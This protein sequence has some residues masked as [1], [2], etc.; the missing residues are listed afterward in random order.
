[1]S[2]SE[3]YLGTVKKLTEYGAFVS[4]P[5]GADGL[6]RRSDAN[7]TLSAGQLV[8]VEIAE[9][10]YGKPI[11]LTRVTDASSDDG[12]SG[13]T[14][15]RGSIDW[16]KGSRDWRAYALIAGVFLAI[17]GIVA[18]IM[19]QPWKSGPYADAKELFA[20]GD[21]DA[22]AVAFDELGSYGGWSGPQADTLAAVSEVA[23]TLDGSAWCAR[24]KDVARARSCLTMT[25]GPHS[26]EALAITLTFTDRNGSPTGSREYITHSFSRDMYVLGDVTAGFNDEDDGV[27][28]SM[29]SMIG[30]MFPNGTKESRLDCND[31]ESV[32]GAD[33]VLTVDERPLD[34]YGDYYDPFGTH[35]TTAYVMK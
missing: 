13:A 2:T 22:A 20:A 29:A 33:F 19:M 12:A 3:R 24:S 10:P 18:L 7:A 1:M 23:S 11:V 15:R 9:M 21:Y 6:L 25:F 28:G 34:E 5:A 4:L 35:T 14:R 8:I 30:I 17:F 31:C 16:S 26:D 27:P 32:R